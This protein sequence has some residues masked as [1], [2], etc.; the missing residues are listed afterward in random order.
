VQEAELFIES[1]STSFDTVADDMPTQFLGLETRP[2]LVHTVGAVGSVTWTPVANSLG[3]TGIF[4]S[5]AQNVILRFSSGG[6]PVSTDG[7]VSG[8][9]PGLAFKFLRDKV[10]S[11]SLFALHSLI[12]ENNYNFF[13]HDWSNHVPDMPYD[14]GFAVTLIRDT[15]AKASDYPTYL[16][17]THLAQY[18]ASGNKVAS[19]RFPWRIIIHSTAKWHS[20]FPST[21]PGLP[22]YEQLPKV[23]VPGPLFSI[24]AID[25]P[26]NDSVITS[27]V[28]IAKVALTSAVTPS[29]FGDKTLFFQHCN[30]ETDMKTFPQWESAALQI[31]A[32]QRNS[33]TLI[34]YPDLPWK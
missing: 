31:Q 15:F 32:A 9:V 25:N 18:D 16:G 21:D 24:F 11:A 26:V 20:A 3:Y 5:G 14:I 33:K 28:L 10:P 23:L 29:M 30:L 1:M 4:A 8:F 19:P 17:L 6:Q 22:F 2:K 13:A 7:N 34:E 12:G 27:A